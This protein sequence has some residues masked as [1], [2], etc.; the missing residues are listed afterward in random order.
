MTSTPRN[1]RRLS[2]VAGFCGSAIATVTLLSFL[3]CEIGTTLNAVAI[4]SLTS[5]VSSAGIVASASLITFMPS[6][7]PSP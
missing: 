6:C 2:S 4:V 1:E 3:F 5:S 7:S